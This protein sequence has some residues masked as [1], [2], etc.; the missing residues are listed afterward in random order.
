M[1]DVQVVGEEAKR[2]KR[3]SSSRARAPGRDPDGHRHERNYRPRGGRPG[4]ANASP[5][6]ACDP[7]DAFREEYVL[8]A[9]RAGAAGS[10]SRTRRPGELELALRSV[11][12]G[13]R[14]AG[15]PRNQRGAGWWAGILLR[16]DARLGA[17]RPHIGLRLGTPKCWKPA[18]AAIQ[19][20]LIPRR[21]SRCA[22]QARARRR[23]SLRR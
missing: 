12:R 7:V 8:Q 5:R 18:A 17:V 3:R 20:G 16:R 22:A 15:A 1:H 9:L 21:P 10:S 6:C 19:A 13:E 2:R 14:L 23:A 11:M 4:C